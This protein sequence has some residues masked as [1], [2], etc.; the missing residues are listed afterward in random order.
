MPIDKV[1]YYDGEDR[2]RLISAK[3][4]MR[5]ATHQLDMSP[6]TYWRKVHPYIKSV[7]EFKGVQRVRKGEVMDL[8][9]LIRRSALSLAE[10]AE[11]WLEADYFRDPDEVRERFKNEVEQT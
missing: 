6:V 8:L 7:M 4:C 5:Y 9:N 3:D 10:A 1:F 11:I 2:D